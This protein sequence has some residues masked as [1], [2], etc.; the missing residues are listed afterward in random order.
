MAQ[1]T[2]PCCP[3]A[4]QAQ[5]EIATAILRHQVRK[6]RQRGW[7]CSPMSDDR[8]IQVAS[9]APLPPP[10][11]ARRGHRSVRPDIR[12]DRRPRSRRATT[13]RAKV[14][15]PLPP[16][17][18]PGG[19]GEHGYRAAHRP[20]PGQRLLL[21]R[22]CDDGEYA[23]IQLNSSA[24][25]APRAA[26]R[27]RS[28]SAGRRRCR[29]IRR[30]TPAEGVGRTPTSSEAISAPLIGAD[31][32]DH[33]HHEADD[34]HAAAHA[35]VDRRQRRGDHAGQRRQRHAAGE[36][37]AVQR[38]MS[39]PNPRT[40]SRLLAPA[41]IIMPSRVL[42]D[43]QYSATASTMQATEG[44]YAVPGAHQPPSLK[45]PASHAGASRRARRCPPRRAQVLEDQ[46]QRIG[47]QHPLQVG[48]AGRGS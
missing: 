25:S 20:A 32:A 14:A 36:H 7:Q 40:M 18:W 39:M 5:R 22:M 45:P 24:S 11:A 19:L 1:L 21:H 44:E 29:C 28:P 41:R 10:S 31:A 26:R 13:R 4:V 23:A 9:V 48:H 16:Q 47:H 12:V 35:R 34:Q 15:V 8:A 17:R 27:A 6:G 2:R 46:D 30:R 33:H 37:D 3:P 42:V 38:W 43:H